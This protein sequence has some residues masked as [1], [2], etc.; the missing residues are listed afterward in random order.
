VQEIMRIMRN[1]TLKIIFIGKLEYGFSVHFES[2][3]NLTLVLHF[4]ALGVLY[5]VMFG[6]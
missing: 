2:Y 4:Q 6:D 3:I 5:I 1:Y